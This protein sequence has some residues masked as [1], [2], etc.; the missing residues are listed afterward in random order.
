MWSG[1]DPFSHSAVGTR[2]HT[3]TGISAGTLHLSTKTTANSPVANPAATRWHAADAETRCD[4][5][6][7]TKP[8]CATYFPTRVMN[9]DETPVT[10]GP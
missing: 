1:A 10:R 7:T 5:I 9:F 3:W 8:G 4:K 2:S 6:A